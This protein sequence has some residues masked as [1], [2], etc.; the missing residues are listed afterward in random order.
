MKH[1]GVR[2]YTDQALDHRV[3]ND[4]GYRW[5]VLWRGAIFVPI[6]G[7]IVYWQQGGITFTAIL[8]LSIVGLFLIGRNALVLCRIQVSEEEINIQ[9]LI[10]L[11][12]GGR[13]RHE[14]IENYLELATN[15]RDTSTAFAGFLK[16]KNQKRIMIGDAGTK[17]F[18]ELNTLLKDIY[19]NTKQ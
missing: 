13:F 17:R 12:S 5:Q 10:P 15:L 9:Y 3:S 11:Q 16:P 14:E 19:P 18:A 1:R 2:R 7:T 6:A 8:V 4:F